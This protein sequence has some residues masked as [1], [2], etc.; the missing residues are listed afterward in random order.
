MTGRS[1]PPLIDRPVNLTDH[2][3]LT[4]RFRCRTCGADSDRPV[5]HLISAYGARTLEDVERRARCLTYRGGLRCAG[6][7]RLELVRRDWGRPEPNGAWVGIY[8]AGPR[9]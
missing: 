3:D 9:G 1:A 2:L 8:P 4:V 5:R 6:P 7:A